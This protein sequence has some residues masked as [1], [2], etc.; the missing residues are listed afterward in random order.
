M[1]LHSHAPG[2][3][4]NDFSVT[5]WFFLLGSCFSEPSELKVT[6][7]LFVSHEGGDHLDWSP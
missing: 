2:N 3:L 1:M 6:F 7:L 4:E 5:N